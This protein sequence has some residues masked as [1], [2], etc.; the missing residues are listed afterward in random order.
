MKVL[1]RTLIAAL[2]LAASLAVFGQEP[3]VETGPDMAACNNEFA[4][5]LVDQQVAESRSVM[6]TDKRVRILIRS[7]DFLWK[8]DQPAARAYFSEAF[9]V[10]TDHFA[11]KGF[12]KRQE[13]SGLI[14]QEPDYRF[15][16]VRS[17][18]KKDGEWAKRLTE[19]MLKEYEKNAADRNVFDKNREIHSIMFMAQES[20]KTNPDLSWYLFRR[21]MKQPLDTHWYF[22]LY[23]VAEVDRNFADALYS[24]LIIAY[25]NESPRR[26]LFL[27]PYPFASPRVFGL[28]R[29]YMSS[30]IPANF[31]M[32]RELQWRFIDT[33]LRRVASYTADPANLNRPAEPHYQPEALY[34]LTALQQLEPII[35]ERFPQMLQRLGVARAQANGMLTDEMRKTLTDQEMRDEQFGLTFDQRM[36]QVEKAD[37]DGKLT[38]NMIVQLV[39]WSPN[40]LTEEQFAMIERWLDKITDENL[41][42]GTVSYFWFLRSKLATK[43]GHFEAARKFS[44]KVPETDHRAILWFDIAEA[45]LKDLNEAASVY[46]TL[47][48]VGRTAR[49]SENSVAKARVLLG[50]ASLYEKVNHTFA[51]DELSDAVKVINRLED[52]DILSSFLR[53]QIT[54][55][56]FGFFTSYQMPGYDME[57]TFRLLSKTDFDMPLSNAKALED[58]YLRTL[59]VIA[60]AQNCIDRP[61]PKP[62]ARA[63]GPAN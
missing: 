16:V 4:K 1:D 33:F 18:A 13:K 51:L 44:L 39:T 7:G 37:S 50:L 45:Q 32:N 26:L 56:G 59:A 61:K 17:I 57:S 38:D 41:R 11:E 12:E 15:E 35:V 55:K 46:Q 21:V 40:S 10:A 14:I 9:K 5:F 52:P 31:G 49:Q 48:D 63:A 2:L 29:I 8:P 30:S 6:Q 43:E 54:G 19:Q 22:G 20:V 36:E 28:D 53:R 3:K 25:R 42:N 27:S 47:T 34:M 24:E 58:K 23:S 60:I 62:A